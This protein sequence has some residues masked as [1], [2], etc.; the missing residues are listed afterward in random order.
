MENWFSGDIIANGIN[1]HYHRTGGDKSAVLI[2][3]GVTDNGITWRRIAG[4]LQQ[5]YDVIMYDQRGHGFSD[6]PQ[7]GYTF[8]VHAE[9]MAGLI[10]ALG[11]KRPHIISHSGG[12]AAAA[13]LAATYSDLPAS[14]VLEDPPWGN[15][16]GGWDAMT[17]GIKEWFLSLGPMTRKDLITACREENPGWREEEIALWVDSKLQVNPNVVQTFDQPAPL[18][19]NTVRQITCPLLLIVGD[20]ERGAVTTSEDIQEIATIWHRGQSVH[21]AGAGHVVHHDCFEEFVAT[22][23]SFLADVIGEQTDSYG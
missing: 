18:W 11:L 22:V 20:P 6:A 17:A 15:G 12:A 21:I 10:A 7:S 19:R 1:I 8:E 13:I 23:K 2:A 14:L 16:W 4:A 5:D 9:D 3:H